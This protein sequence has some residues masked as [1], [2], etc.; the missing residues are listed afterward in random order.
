MWET[1]IN[2]SVRGYVFSKVPPDPDS[3]G[4]PYGRVSV[5]KGPPGRVAVSVIWYCEDS[6]KLRSRFIW[7][8]GIDYQHKIDSYAQRHAGDFD[9]KPALIAAIDNEG[10]VLYSIDLADG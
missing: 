3:D 7:Q 1:A 2:R 4:V 10:S 5:V 8:G 6:Y 9:T